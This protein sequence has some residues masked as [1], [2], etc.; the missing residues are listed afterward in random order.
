LDVQTA[1]WIAND[2]G[3]D[4]IAGSPVARNT[5]ILLW[6]IGASFQYA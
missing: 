1:I 6:V 5:L 2:L 4:E 3:A